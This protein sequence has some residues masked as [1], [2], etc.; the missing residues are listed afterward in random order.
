MVG[1]SGWWINHEAWYKQKDSAGCIERVTVAIAA[2]DSTA[3]VA[4]RTVAVAV[5]ITSANGSKRMSALVR[6]RFPLC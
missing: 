3:T 1:G 5:N 2:A 6:Y 4:G